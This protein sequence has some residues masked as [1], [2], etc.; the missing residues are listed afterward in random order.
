MSDG[1]GVNRNGLS[2]TY[3]VML[4]TMVG[5]GPLDSVRVERRFPT[6]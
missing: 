6:W 2:E 1:I 5:M 3:K 4:A